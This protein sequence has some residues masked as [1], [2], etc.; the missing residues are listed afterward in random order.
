MSNKTKE[1]KLSTLV[2]YGQMSENAIIFYETNHLHGHV[3]SP[4][5]TDEHFLV[6]NGT[7]TLLL[8]TLHKQ[9]DKCRGLNTQLLELLDDLASRL[10]PIHLSET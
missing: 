8:S 2:M 7:N 4:H 6:R 3:N 9:I 1:E 5:T 10:C